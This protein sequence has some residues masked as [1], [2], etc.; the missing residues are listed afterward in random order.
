MAFRRLKADDERELRKTWKEGRQA[1][2]TAVV[3]IDPDELSP[4]A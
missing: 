2:T 3:G 1:T 4:F